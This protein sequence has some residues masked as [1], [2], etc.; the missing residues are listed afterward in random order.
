MWDAINTGSPEATFPRYSDPGNIVDPTVIKCR[1]SPLVED[2]SF[3]LIKRHGKTRRDGY[4]GN[5]NN[6]K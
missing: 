4:K 2:K 1:K 5:R 6:S 3:S